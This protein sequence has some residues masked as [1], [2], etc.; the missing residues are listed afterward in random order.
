M[1]TF[2]LSLLQHDM[3][4]SN[5]ISD[6]VYL[7]LF[8]IQ[9]VCLRLAIE[10]VVP[11]VDMLLPYLNSGIIVLVINLVFKRLGLELKGRKIKRRVLESL[12]WGL[13][14]VFAGSYL[15]YFIQTHLSG[16]PPLAVFF[17]LLLVYVVISQMQTK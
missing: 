7:R 2:S 17:I 1:V 9:E 5:H 13:F 11:L 6:S 8:N 10:E 4:V 3:R 14:L 15:S 16:F 12:I